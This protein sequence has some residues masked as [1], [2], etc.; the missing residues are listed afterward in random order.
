MI[1]FFK[2][3][4]EKEQAQAEDLGFVEKV[5]RRLKDIGKPKPPEPKSDLLCVVE[6]CQNSKEAGQTHVCSEHVRTQ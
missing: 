2:S 4:E 1:D 3:K 6:G 5:E